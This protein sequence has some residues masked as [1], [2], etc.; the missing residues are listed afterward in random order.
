MKKIFLFMAVSLSMFIF[1]ACDGG[2]PDF[3]DYGEQGGH[4]YGQKETN[5]IISNWTDFYYND[6]Y[7]MISYYLFSFGKDGNYV[8]ETRYHYLSTSKT[9]SY[10]KK[11]GTYTIKD[12]TLILNNGSK[13]TKKKMKLDKDT[14]YLGSSKYLRSNNVADLQEGTVPTTSAPAVYVVVYNE[15][16]QIKVVMIPYFGITKYDFQI[17]GSN[18]NNNTK[19]RV[20]TKTKKQG[21]HTINISATAYTSDGR[22]Y[23]TTNYTYSYKHT[24]PLNYYY[25]KSSGKV[26]E[27]TYAEAKVDHGIGTTSN[28]EQ[29]MFWAEKGSKGNNWI[30]F[31]KAVPYY[32][33]VS[34]NSW[35]A[36]KYTI[37]QNAGYYQYGG[38]YCENGS[39]L[40]GV[41]GTLT[42]TH[43]TTN[44]W[45]YDFDTY[46]FK[47]HFEGTVVK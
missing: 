38:A 29:L 42:I 28:L 47:G 5:T 44:Y 31:V 6:T 23:P 9:D 41:E 43:P 2:S 11:T 39:L 27:I 24:L 21:N 3:D 34:I 20:I 4:E 35:I 25:M 40:G 13:E 36:G 10:Y 1:T 46:E 18:Y 26:Y 14:L 16:E 8:E 22:K 15:I 17:D 12:D 32:E 33:G 45:T 30:Q 19:C 7:K 37:V